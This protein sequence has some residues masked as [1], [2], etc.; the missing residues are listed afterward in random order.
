MNTH[1]PMTLLKTTVF[2]YKVEVIPTNNDGP[3]HFA[4]T[5]NSGQDTS[6]DPYVAG[7]WAFLVNVGSIDSLSK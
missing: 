5:D 1:V 3:L 4:L 6:T 7:E 2:S